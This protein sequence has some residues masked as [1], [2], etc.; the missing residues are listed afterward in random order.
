[1]YCS[2][3]ESVFI[4]SLMDIEILSQNFY[5]TRRVKHNIT[6]RRE[7]KESPICLGQC[8]FVILLLISHLFKQLKSGVSKLLLLREIKKLRNHPVPSTEVYGMDPVSKPGCN[9]GGVNH[10]L[11]CCALQWELDCSPAWASSTCNRNPHSSCIV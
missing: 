9:P 7:G 8:I 1:M 6:D 11:P 2:Y 4:R 5:E 3:P 10:L